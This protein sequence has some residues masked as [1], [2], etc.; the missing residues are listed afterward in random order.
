MTE[1][2]KDQIDF[3]RSFAAVRESMRLYLLLRDVYINIE[4]GIA[5]M[6]DETQREDCRKLFN[7]LNEGSAMMGNALSILEDRFDDALAEVRR[8]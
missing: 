2:T 6:S 8:G 4:R 5:L 1:I 7:R 3:I